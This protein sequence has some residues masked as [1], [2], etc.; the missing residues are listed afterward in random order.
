MVEWRRKHVD[1]KI[2]DL[3][4]YISHANIVTHSFVCIIKGYH[5]TY[6]SKKLV[7]RRGASP[8][9]REKTRRECDFVCGD[10]ALARRRIAVWLC[11]L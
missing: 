6:A 2:L 10:A 1:D 9:G 11:G 4:L 3:P 7:R 5:Q 8:R